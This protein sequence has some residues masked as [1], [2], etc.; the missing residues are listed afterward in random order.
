M[1]VDTELKVVFVRKTESWLMRLAAWGL[2]VLRACGMRVPTGQE[3]LVSFYTTFRIPL[4][5]KWPRIYFPKYTVEPTWSQVLE[6]EL[7]HAEQFRSFWGAVRNSLRYLTQRGRFA[8]EGPAYLVDI[9]KGWHTPETAAM[10]LSR[11]YAV[12]KPTTF[13]MADWFKAHLHVKETT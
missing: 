9:R 4:F 8:V 12:S 6:H 11:N 1:V 3:F 2:D 13:E 7:V 10:A 5:H